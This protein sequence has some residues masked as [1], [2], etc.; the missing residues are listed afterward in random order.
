MTKLQEMLNKA[1]EDANK[2]GLYIDLIDTDI[3]GVITLYANSR[4]ILLVDNGAVALVNEHGG[5]IK[6]YKKIGSAVK[7]L[8][9]MEDV[10]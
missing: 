10:Y 2:Y 4:S 9:S 7:A 5:T 3:D 6:V 8:V 1:Q